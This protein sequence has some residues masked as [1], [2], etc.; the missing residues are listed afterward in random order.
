MAQSAASDILT[1]VGGAENVVGLTHCATR[2]RFQLRDAS[3]VDGAAVEA[4]PGVMGAVPQSGDRY[5]VVI[6]GAVQTV[7]NDIMA[8]PA[9][10]SVGS[11][12]DDDD[13]AAVKARERA[14]GPRGKIA[15]LD[16]LFEFL[17]DSFRPILGALLGASLFI[18]F[19]A[20]MG[21][22]GVIGN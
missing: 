7:Y 18:T 14:K 5:Q 17:S 8:L 21:T 13:A 22:L 11:A 10:A 12:S 19:M 4:I 2:L 16:S 9:M 3:V 6:G 20:L 1:R 15:W